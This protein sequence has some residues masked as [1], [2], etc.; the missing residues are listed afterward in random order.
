MDRGVVADRRPIFYAWLALVV[1]VA[2]EATYEIFRVGGPSSLYEDWIHGVVLLAS[3][4]LILLRAALERSDR[5]AWLC[6]GIAM[7]FWT[8]ATIAWSIVYGSDAQAPYPTFADAL[9]LLWYPLVALGLFYLIRTR[10]PQFELHRWMDG[11]AVTLVALIVGFGFVVQPASSHSPRG[12]LATIVDF[13]YPVLDIFLIG[14]MLG[15]YGLL[16]WRPDAMWLILGLAIVTMSIGDVVFSVQVERG[17]AVSS[18]YDFVWTMGA[19]LLAL[20]AWLPTRDVSPGA[21]RATGLRAVALA[22]FAQAVAIGIQVVS[23]YRDLGPAERIVTV[24]LLLV[25]ST[26]VVLARPK[27]ANEEGA[28]GDQDPERR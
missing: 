23:L 21:Q 25:V 28:D 10:V 1:L 5:K 2:L 14:A 19:L 26:Q 4:V 11:I 8:V 6:L 3:T 27:P 7:V 20:A 15:I 22:L 12:V 24:V 9:W 13:A 18:S 16:S 17:V